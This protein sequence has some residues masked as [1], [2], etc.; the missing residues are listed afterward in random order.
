[1]TTNPAHPAPIDPADPLAPLL[2]DLTGAQ[3]EAVEATEGPLLILAAAGSGKTRVI[4]RRIAALVAM[5]IPPWQILALTFTNK[6]AGEMRERVIH[7]LS[8]RASAEREIRGLTITTFHSLCARLLRR[9]APLMV[10][11]PRWGIGADYTIYDT[12]DQTALIKRTLKDMDLSTS[13]WPPR[14]LLSAISAAKN[15]MKD[16]AAFSAEA[17]DFH[18]RTV[19]RVYEAYERGLRAANAVDFDDL[20]LL[21]VR[22]LREREDA[23]AEVRERWRYLMI[24]E[25]QDT[26]RVQFVLS[27]LVCGADE[28]R[29]PNVCVV[30]DP[31]QS[32]YGWRGADIT[33]ILEFEE[34]YPGA[35]VVRLGQN[36][37]STAPILAVADHLI[38]HNVRR[39]HKEL[40][41]TEPGGEAPTVVRCRDERHEAELVADWFRSLA[42]DEDRDLAWKDMA[43]FYRNN[44]LSRVMEDALRSAGMP[45]VIA[46]GTAF[47]QREEVRD[48]I[49]YLRVVANPADDVS[50]RRVINKPA[51]GLGAT[52]IGRLD[53]FAEAAGITLVEALRR[54]GEAPGMTPQSVKAAAKFVASLDGWTGSGTFMGAGVSGS[55][56]ELASRVVAESGLEGFYRKRQAKSGEESDEDRLANLEELVSSAREFEIEFVP[57]EDPAFAPTAEQRAGGGE[58]GEPETPPLLALLRAYLESV[59]LVS[60]ADQV[61]PAN[62]AITL[63]TLHAAK[64]LEFPA[65]AIIGLEE[66]LLPSMRAMESEASLEEERRLMFVGVTRAMRLLSITSAGSRRHRGETQRTIPSRFLRELPEGGV[67]VSDQSEPLYGADRSGPSG[68]AWDDF[69]FD[70]T[71]AGERLARARAAG[72]AGGSGQRDPSGLGPGVGVRH[73]QFGE[74]R[75][76]EITGFGRNRRAKVA[77]RGA[78]TKTLVLEHARLTPL[79]GADDDAPPF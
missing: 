56:S 67:V 62:G 40:F 20:L 58:G 43:V 76:V 55:L 21:T 12:D 69:D 79:T 64:G 26:N 48:A 52:A 22:L 65:V 42:H 28:G 24:D 41:T 77:F 29:P 34:Q 63:M 4:T 57:D 49:A 32:I 6:A 36:F 50:L 3:R 7:L 35:R 74:G 23:A 72:P 16:A 54:A 39:K 38:R 37:R 8:S 31:D 45:Y 44:A 70:Q 53:A 27:T 59:T 11:A 33:N 19:A 66:G 10:D 71:G 30:G 1:M 17:N 46:R 18:A 47:Y 5:G 60:D 68:G 9:Y 75:I 13:N 73:P 2:A 14:S 25:Y 15:E 61:D 51:R 78:G